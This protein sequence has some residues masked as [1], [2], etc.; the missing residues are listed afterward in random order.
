MAIRNIIQEGENSPQKL[1]QNHR[2]HS[3]LHQLLDDMRDTHINADGAGWQR[4]G[5]GFKGVRSCPSERRQLSGDSK[6]YY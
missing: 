3:R 5:R 2:V 4:S 1:P 6:S